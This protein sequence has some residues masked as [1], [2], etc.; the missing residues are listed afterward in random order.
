MTRSS[1]AESNLKWSILKWT[2]ERLSY[3]KEEESEKSLTVCPTVHLG[4][5]YRLPL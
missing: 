4:T 2:R 1:E 5:K 3:C